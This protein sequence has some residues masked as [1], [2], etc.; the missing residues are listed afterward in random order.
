MRTIAER[1][2]DDRVTGGCHWASP[3]AP[4]SN[5]PTL[6]QSPPVLGCGTPDGRIEHPP[7][8][9]R[10]PIRI[11]LTQLEPTVANK[12]YP[13]VIRKATV[14]TR[15]LFSSK[16]V[17]SQRVPATSLFTSVSAIVSRDLRRPPPDH[18]PRP[19]VSKSRP[20]LVS[21]VIELVA[22]VPEIRTREGS[23]R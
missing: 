6:N 3:Q 18:P 15:W 17:N 23:V 1:L 14:E 20:P 12:R 8:T 7:I 11:P 5:Y 2:P 19:E 13:R 4:A 21:R 9:P 10:S 16:R 22:I